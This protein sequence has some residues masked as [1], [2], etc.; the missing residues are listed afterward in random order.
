[1]N[2][3]EIKEYLTKE[4]IPY[5]EKD[6]SKNNI[7][8]KAIDCTLKLLEFYG[9]YYVHSNMRYGEND[10]ET[11]LLTLEQFIMLQQ[12]EDGYNKCSDYVNSV[13]KGEFEYIEENLEE[14]GLTPQDVYN[15]CDDD[16]FQVA[17]DSI[18]SM[19]DTYNLT[20]NIFQSIADGTLQILGSNDEDNEFRIYKKG[21]VL[22]TNDRKERE[23]KTE[24]LYDRNN[25]DEFINNFDDILKYI[26]ENDVA[27]EDISII[28]VL[29][30]IGDNYC[31]NKADN[32][33]EKQLEVINEMLKLL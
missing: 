20:K 13:F 33:K 11:I 16:G 22:R 19:W 24:K 5:L 12:I 21:T 26:D 8:N 32:I 17:Y 2:K 25:Y 18:T 4:F 30:F 14:E 31:E 10:E 15:I 6:I 9:K 7:Y 27:F 28:G 3:D 23:E 29:Y 1:M